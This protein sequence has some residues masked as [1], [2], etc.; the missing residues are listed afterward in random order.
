MLEKVSAAAK[1]GG[2]PAEKSAT[3]ESKPKPLGV[4]RAGA[5]VAAWH[6]PANQ[7]K[8]ALEKAAEAKLAAEDAAAEKAAAEKAAEENAVSRSDTADTETL[9]Q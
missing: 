7:E 4:T 3:V 2:N 5:E 1:A 6:Q 9:M 8:G